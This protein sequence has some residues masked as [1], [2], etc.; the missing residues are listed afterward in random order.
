MNSL[1]EMIQAF[2]PEVYTSVSIDT[3]LLVAR[4]K[5]SPR[6]A[7]ILSILL[8]E[9]QASNAQFQSSAIRQHIHCLR[10]KLKLFGDNTI[11]SMGMGFYAI[12]DEIKENIQRYVYA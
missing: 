12:P 8:K 1:P 11:S 7:N 3:T 9:Y 4:L 5:L 2:K 6:E 10:N